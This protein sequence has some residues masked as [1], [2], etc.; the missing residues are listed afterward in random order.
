MPSHLAQGMFLKEEFSVTDPRG[1]HSTLINA[2]EGEGRGGGEEEEE[3]MWESPQKAST[4]LFPQHSIV[5]HW[6]QALVL[7]IREGP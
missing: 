5:C 4:H 1:S 6:L 7:P 2:E 3:R